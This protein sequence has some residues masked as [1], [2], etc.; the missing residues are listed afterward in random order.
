MLIKKICL[1]SVEVNSWQTEIKVE[2]S[3][4]AS[5]VVVVAER[6]LARMQ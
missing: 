1:L 5:G 3:D 4:G 2:I 6:G